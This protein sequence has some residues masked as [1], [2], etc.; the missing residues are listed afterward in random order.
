[1]KPRSQ[2]LSR[3]ASRSK[4]PAPARTRA[5]KDEPAKAPAKARPKDRAAADA[6][7]KT[8]RRPASPGKRN[9]PPHQPPSQDGKERP[10]GRLE[11]GA[12]TRGQV[13]DALLSLLAE[14]NYAP[15]TQEVSERAGVSRRLVFHHF[16]DTESMLA[17]FYQKQTAILDALVTPIADSL[18]LPG[19]LLALVEQRARIYE[20]IT[21]TRRAAL[22]RE[23]VSPPLAGRLNA[24]RSIKR[25]Q[26]EAVFAPEIASCHQSV[27][28]EIAAALGCAASF[29]T[30][31]SL[32]RHQQLDVEAAQ[33]VLTHLLSGIL[34]L[35][36][37]GANL[38]VLYGTGARRSDASK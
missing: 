29:S 36:P 2:L 4:P 5:E 15:S 6:V 25:A 11:R 31:E 26:I 16:T 22:T 7:K 30:W 33:R 21:H 24:F 20:R 1:M 9:P 8:G 17:A 23:Y 14:G 10:D 38:V 27:R 28:T 19:R 3:A 12:R 18:P 34:R 32:R 13:L 37:G 35:T